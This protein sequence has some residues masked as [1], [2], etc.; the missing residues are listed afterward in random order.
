MQ[1]TPTAMAG[2]ALQ[3]WGSSSIVTVRWLGGWE[4]SWLPGMLAGRA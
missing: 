1:S 3:R 4:L 2:Y